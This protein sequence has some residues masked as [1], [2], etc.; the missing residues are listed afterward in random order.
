MTLKLSEALT[1]D[2]IFDIIKTGRERRAI[3]AKKEVKPYALRLPA[4]LH[5][6][7]ERLAARQRVSVNQL[8]ADVMAGYTEKI[9][10]AERL[11]EQL[12]QSTVIYDSQGRIVEKKP[13]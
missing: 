10:E 3:M 6:E 12:D 8:I 11:M 7:I 9:A 1:F 4:E 13:F 2:I 5:K